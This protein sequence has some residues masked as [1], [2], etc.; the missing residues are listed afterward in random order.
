MVNLDPKGRPVYRDL[1]G[2]MGLMEKRLMS[3]TMAIGGLEKLTLAFQLLE[4][5]Q[6]KF[7]YR[8]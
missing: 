5:T 7:L 1:K 4:L 2:L 3:E 6:V 8:M